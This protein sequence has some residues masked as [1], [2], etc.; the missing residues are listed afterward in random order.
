MRRLLVLALAVGALLGLLSSRRA[1]AVERNFAGSGQFDYHFVVGG[2]SPGVITP[3]DG[4]TT[5]LALKIAVDVNDKVS[6]N[7]KACYGCHGFEVPMAYLDYRVADELFF[8]IGRFSPQL[9]AFNL[10][11]DPANHRLSSKPLIYD[12][13]RMLRRVEWNM[14]VIPSPF[15]D[16]GVEVGG[17]HWFGEKAQLDYAVYAISGFKAPGDATDLDWQLNRQPYYTDNNSRPSVGGR[18]A[19]T[20]K[21]GETS[22]LTLGGST[23]YGT[24]D[25]DRKQSYLFYGADA[26]LRVARTNLRVEWLARRQ[27]FDASDPTRFKY[28]VPS[29]GGNFFVKQGGYFEIEHPLAKNVDGIFRYD[30][31]YRTGNVLVNSPLRR[32]SAVQRFTVGGMFTVD[33]AFRIKASTEIWQFSDPD[34][35]D[36]SAARS[37]PSLAI[38]VHLGVVGTY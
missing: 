36:K 9:G 31:M 28:V 10:R 20:I 18:L 37:D 25:P 12:M 5:E 23:Q 1:G 26:A 16:N 4:A 21:L 29:D 24:F 19:L 32:Q 17:T 11:H 22:D 35:D 13:G 7:I 38:G 33:R 8:R 15:P 3:R 30:V 2:K 27:T 14:G 6:A 34:V